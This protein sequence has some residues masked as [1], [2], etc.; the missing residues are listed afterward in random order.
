LAFKD[1][2]IPGHGVDYHKDGFGSPIGNWKATELKEGKKQSWNLKAASRSKERSTSCW[3]AM[4][5]ASRYV[6]GLHG[7]VW[8]SRFV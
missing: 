5:T 1:K 6:F 7:E 4:A 2:E 3:S 8:R